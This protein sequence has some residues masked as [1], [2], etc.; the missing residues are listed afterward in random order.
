MTVLSLNLSGRKDSPQNVPAV[1]PASE[2]Y[3]SMASNSIKLLT[4]NSHPL[5]AKAV[6]ARFVEFAQ[7]GSQTDF[8]QTGHRAHQDHGLAVL[9]SRNKCHDR[10]VCER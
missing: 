9:E 6:A 10:R 5:L 1:I 8:V 7:N 3:T 2:N 4:G